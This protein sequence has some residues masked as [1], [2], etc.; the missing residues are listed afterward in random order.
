MEMV[1]G[2]APSSC[3]WIRRNKN[4][5]VVRRITCIVCQG[6]RDKTRSVWALRVSASVVCRDLR[7]SGAPVLLYPNTRGVKESSRCHSCGFPLT[8]PEN[9]LYYF[10]TI[11]PGAGV[12]SRGAAPLPKQVTVGVYY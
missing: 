10:G 5:Q 11:Q 9:F 12:F 8:V 2:A 3:G 1:W 7:G 4:K 6:K